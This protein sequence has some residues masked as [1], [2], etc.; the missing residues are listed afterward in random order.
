M[1]SQTSSQ[2]QLQDRHAAMSLQLQHILTGI[3]VGGLKKNGQPLID[4][5]TIFIQKRNQRGLS[6]L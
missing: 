3:R 6:G 1:T 4:R 5:L 2:D